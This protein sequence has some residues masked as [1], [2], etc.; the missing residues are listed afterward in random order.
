MVKALKWWRR[1]KEP[2]PKYPKSYP[3]E[4]MLGLNCANGMQS[5]AQAVVDALLKKFSEALMAC[6]H[7]LRRSALIICPSLRGIPAPRDL[8][9]SVNT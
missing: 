1:V 9:R 8:H 6:R 3:L 5:V 7:S 2:L 4:H